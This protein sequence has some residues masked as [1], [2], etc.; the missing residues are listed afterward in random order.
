MATRKEVTIYDIARALNLSPSTV[1]RGLNGNPAIRKITIRRIKE[2]A[3]SMGYQRNTFASNLREN[4]S[5]TIGV[6]LPRLDSQFQ[7]SVVAGI[8][9]V[10]QNS[11]F[12]L[13]ISQSRE[14]ADKEKESIQTMY[15]SR[16][17]GLLISLAC[18]TC[19][20]EHLNVFLRKEIPVVLF[21]RV[22]EHPGRKLTQVIINNVKAG[23]Q[24]T[25]HMIEQ[26][27]KSILFVSDDLTSNVYS[28]RLEGYRKAL[29][30]AGIAYRNEQV[31]VTQLDEGSGERTLEYMKRK[32]LRPDGIFVCND[33]SAVSVICSLKQSGFRV[34]QDVAVVG[35]ND[36]PISRVIDPALSTIRYPGFEMGETAA[37]TLI[38]MMG[39]EEEVLA[40][41][42]LLEHSLIVRQSSVRKGGG[43]GASVEKIK[44]APD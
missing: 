43:V 12:N 38:E 40:K 42:I 30:E 13:I 29:V 5:N 36:V 2:T 15:N 14:S 17:D 28:E 8:E 4:R 7:A 37:A 18:N 23:Y 27:C 33:T 34:P 21:D 3:E 24:A 32:R 22:K 20:M 25:R 39:R 35:F 31:L 41:T 19:N 10:V 6:I 26:G 11:G 44:A 9:K 16:V 1:S